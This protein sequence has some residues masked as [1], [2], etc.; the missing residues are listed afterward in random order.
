[1][2]RATQADSERVGAARLELDEALR[3]YVQLRAEDYRRELA[4]PSGFP[5]EERFLRALED[6]RRVLDTALDDFIELAAM[7]EA[8]IDRDPCHD[9]A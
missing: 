2:V 8:G 1:M 6:G 3:R 5:P 4:H 7:S 9:P